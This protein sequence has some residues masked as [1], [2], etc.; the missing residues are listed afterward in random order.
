MEM[1]FR[2]FGRFRLAHTSSRACA[3]LSASDSSAARW[4]FAERPIPDLSTSKK[5]SRRLAQTADPRYFARSEVRWKAQKIDFIA[6]L[7]AKLT[8][9]GSGPK[10]D[11]AEDRS[12]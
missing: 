2:E 11:R 4:I 3:P 10:F 6:I 5:P 12:Q 1:S 9:R 8:Q 7:I